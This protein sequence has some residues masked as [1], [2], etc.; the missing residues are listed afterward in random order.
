MEAELTALPESR[1][2]AVLKF[3]AQRVQPLLKH[4]TRGRELALTLRQSWAAEFGRSF[5]LA[6]FILLWIFIV[7]V[8]G[9]LVFTAGA[10][11][12]SVGLG[13]ILTGIGGAVAFVLIA[14]WAGRLIQWFDRHG[15]GGRGVRHR[16]A[17]AGFAVRSAPS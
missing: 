4:P 15:S 7:P 12:F 13:T 6:V 3:V 16:A 14:Y 5:T 11:R 8:P 10:Y 2:E 1:R 17:Q 9:L